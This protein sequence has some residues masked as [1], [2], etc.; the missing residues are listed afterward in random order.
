MNFEVKY[1]L[2]FDHSLKRIAKKHK[3]IRDDILELINQLEREP[4]T[5]IQVRTN[6]YKIRL[7]ISSSNKGK[8]GGARVVTYVYN[9]KEI[10][11]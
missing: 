7:N 6:L 11:F 5:G 2:D 8:S 3:G 1:T 4:R 10:V 9:T